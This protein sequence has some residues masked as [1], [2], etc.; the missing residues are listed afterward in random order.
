MEDKTPQF[1]NEA[2][3]SP[4]NWTKH[5]LQQLIREKMA[6]YLFIVVSNR[7]PYVYK[8]KKG[9]VECL[10]GAGGV[11]TAL[12]P[13]MQACGG[14]WVANSGGDA[15]RKVCD[16]NSKIRVPSEDPR[17]TLKWVWIITGIPMRQ[18]GLC[19]IWPFSGRYSA[20]MTG[21][22]MFR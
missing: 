21:I 22:I 17:Y 10:R 4:V 12:D 2:T 3:S 1:K 19:V 14:L 15:D 16:K 20:G 11:V 6:D 13:V 18:Y 9:K 7:Q 8:I 5:N